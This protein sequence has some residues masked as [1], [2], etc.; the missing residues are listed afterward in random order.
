MIRIYVDTEEQKEIMIEALDDSSRCLFLGN[1]SG[2]FNRKECR[3][4]IEENIVFHV[5]SCGRK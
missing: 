1:A 4:C 3:D 5:D 2:C